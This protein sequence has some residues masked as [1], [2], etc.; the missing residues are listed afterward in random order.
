MALFTAYSRRGL[1]DGIFQMIYELRWVV[2]CGF[3]VFSL[4]QVLA[5]NGI[6]SVMFV[7]DEEKHQAV[8][9]LA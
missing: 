6:W 7:L 5:T 2:S 8:K 9:A 1:I 3:V 4:G